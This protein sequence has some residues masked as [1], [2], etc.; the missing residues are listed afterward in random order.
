MNQ[1]VADDLERW[2]KLG[3]AR[4]AAVAAVHLESAMRR[5]G[6]NGI[7]FERL[8]D[9]YMALLDRR[10]FLVRTPEE[11]SRTIREIQDVGAGFDL[12][13][14]SEALAGVDAA[15]TECLNLARERH[16]PELRPFVPRC[17]CGHHKERP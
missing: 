4:S 8:R 9:A 14:L 12:Y 17:R 16:F 3:E 5:S 11:L 6:R 10:G 1:D 2:L 15:S 7:G 13:D